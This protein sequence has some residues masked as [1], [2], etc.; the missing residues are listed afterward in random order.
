MYLWY[1]IILLL[2]RYIFNPTQPKL[3]SIN[4]YGIPDLIN[5]VSIV[6]KFKQY[7]EV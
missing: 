7:S 6:L 5:T 1:Y 3:T 4:K 2:L